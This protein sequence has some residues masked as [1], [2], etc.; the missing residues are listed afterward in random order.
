MGNKFKASIIFVSGETIGDEDVPF[1]VRVIFEPNITDLQV[2]PPAYIIARD[3]F[4]SDVEAAI[5]RYQELTGEEMEFQYVAP[6]EDPFP[7][8]D[9]ELVEEEEEYD[10]DAP[11]FGESLRPKTVN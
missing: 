2:A 6:G 5:R 10:E 8:E 4:M 9:E 3:M 7:L 1:S 11:A